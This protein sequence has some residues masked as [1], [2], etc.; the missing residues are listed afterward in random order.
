MTADMIGQRAHQ[1][2]PVSN[3]EAFA[4]AEHWRRYAHHASVVYKDRNGGWHCIR[5]GR[6]A[7]KRA[8]LAMGTHG[9]MNV[10]GQGHRCRV[11]WS[12]ACTRLRTVDQL[13]D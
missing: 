5:Y 8:M 9:H 13:L 7:I 6:L 1:I 12:E 3:I 4:A 11:G 2:G 10:I